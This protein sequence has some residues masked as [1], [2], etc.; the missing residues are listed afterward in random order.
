MSKQNRRDFVKKSALGGLGL[1][2]ASSMSMSAKSYRNIIGANDRLHV[3]I[4]GLG[5]RLG[6][7]YDPIAHKKSNV[8]L[9]YLCDPMESQMAKAATKFKEH[10]DYALKL[11][12]DIFKVLDDDKVDVLINSTPDHWH[13]PGSIMAL[14]S[15][16]HVYVEKPSS[17]TME[18]NELLVEAAKK[19]DKVVQMGNQQRSSGQTQEIIKKIHD[20]AIGD[21][22]KAVAF[23]S[24][25]RG[26]VP[27]QK[28][29]AVP[30]GLDW[31]LWQGPAV[32]REYTSETWN[33]NWH[34]YGWNY[35]TAEMG[36]NATHELDVARWALNVNY[37][38]MVEVNAA[39]RH[40]V[41]DGW[42]MYDTMLARFT[43]EDNKQIEWDGKSRNAYNTYG[44]GRG[45]IIYGTEGTVFVNRS[46]HKLYNR[47]GELV[48]ESKGKT[49]ESGIALGGGGNMSTTHVMNFFDTV[50]G[51][52]TL[53]APIDD[54]NISMSMVHYANVSSRINE[55]F[56]IDSKN[57]TMFNQEAMKHW[58]KPYEESWKSKFLL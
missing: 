9:L 51:K 20:K 23:Y 11:E 36:N 25:G 18:E 44:S 28:K 2:S 5:R 24:N 8:R 39:K 12:K 47:K 38:Q 31:N 43:F 4:A 13:T 46:H 42:E 27:L 56:E 57:G 1:V 16:K 17:C 40:F 50:R 55:N 33:Y 22:Y 26:A 37:P 7:F 53:N 41:D 54:A 45:V 32:H 58:G 30:E 19:Y 6:A 49:G 34:W 52:A 3:A 15:G 10:I 14:K 21:A 35:A 29:A 48:E